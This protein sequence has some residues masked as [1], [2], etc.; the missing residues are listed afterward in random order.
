[1]TQWLRCFLFRVS[2]S[3]SAPLFFSSLSFW[4][5]GMEGFVLSFQLTFVQVANLPLLLPLLTS[6]RWNNNP[7]PH[8]SFIVHT[9]SALIRR[10]S[11]T[12]RPNVW[13]AELLYLSEIW[14]WATP[15][16]LHWPRCKTRWVKLLVSLQLHLRC[17]NNEGIWPDSETP[18][19]LLPHRE[20]MRTMGHVEMRSKLCIVSLGPLVRVENLNTHTHT[21]LF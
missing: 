15:A 3:S 6:Q 4:L 21:W 20:Q 10:A 18:T 17:F 12:S 14:H 19:T 2:S 11:V 13:I 8:Y 7:L 16:A 5:R 1:M 9:W